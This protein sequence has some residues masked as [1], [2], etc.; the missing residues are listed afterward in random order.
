MMSQLVLQNIQRCLQ[1]VLELSDAE[2]LRIGPETT[3]LTL[4]RWNSLAHVQLVLEVERVFGITFEGDE[5][6]S[7]ASVSAI[8]AAIGR[9]RN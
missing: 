6:A 4:P 7:L 5:I 3:P 8:A 1:T 9:A 2:A